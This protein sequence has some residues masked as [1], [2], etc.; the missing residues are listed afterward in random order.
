MEACENLV[1]LSRVVYNILT[2]LEKTFSLSFLKILFS[3]I[4]LNEYPNLITTLNSF[5]RGM[6]LLFLNFYLFIIIWL[7]WVF[8]ALSR[9]SLVSVSRAQ[10]LLQC[11]SFSI[12]WLF[13]QRITGSRA[14]RLQQLRRRGSRAQAQQSRCMGLAALW[15][16]GSSQI[17]DQTH[18][19]CIGR[20]VLDPRTTREVQG[21]MNTFGAF[22]TRQK[23]PY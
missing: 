6:R 4:N 5:T 7:Y 11:L 1:P 8:I 16:V 15:H 3:Q 2:Q 13:F 18:I 12:Q 22:G 9:L 21:F 10:T 14:L 20:W 23:L 17:R 19:P